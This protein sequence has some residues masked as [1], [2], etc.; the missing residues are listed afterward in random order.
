MEFL[1]SISNLL[2]K[3][4]ETYWQKASASLDASAKIYGFRVD[5]VHSETFKF[6]GGLSRNEKTNE[7]NNEAGDLDN[8]NNDKKEKDKR[9]NKHNGF[10][11]LEK[12]V[13]KINLTKYDLEFEIDPLFKSMTA[14]FNESGAR[15]LLLNNFP[16][17]DNLDV[18][19]ESKPS[20]NQGAYTSCSTNPNDLSE[21][22]KK[23]V[24]EFVSH[25]TID[26]LTSMQIAPDLGYFKQTRNLETTIEK[27]FYHNFMNELDNDVIDEMDENLEYPA[28][29]NLLADN[30]SVGSQNKS[31]LD[32]GIGQVNDEGM[33]EMNFPGNNISNIGGYNNG[34]ITGE[35]FSMFKHDDIMEYENKF[36]DGSRNI[37][38]N[39]PQFQNFIK[40]FTKLDKNLYLNRPGLFK[41]GEK[42]N[43]RIKKEEKLFE[44]DVEKEIG[45]NEIFGKE[46]KIKK[47]VDNSGFGSKKDNKK[48]VKQFY[49]YDRY[50]V[51]RLFTIPERNIFSNNNDINPNAPLNSE[52]PIPEDEGAMD[53]GLSND[54][55]EEAKINDGN[56][57][58]PNSTFVKFDQ[59]YEKKFG[60]LY[61]RFDVRLIKQNLW[62]TFESI[63][64]KKPEVVDFKTV[65]AGMSSKIEKN[66]LDNISTS[67]CF[68]CFLHLCNEKSKLIII[69]FVGLE[70]NQNNDQTF[71][72]TQNTTK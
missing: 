34:S 51:F 64:E 36:G 37:L 71:Y 12:D 62:K 20:Y 49:N 4:E 22:N 44:F 1:E 9:A 45:R 50:D 67:T 63:E 11:T 41:P 28:E 30:I 68:V 47:V 46:S 42:E 26:E 10:S 6:L 19:L 25:M 18:L 24:D 59:E 27:S 53:P 52:N 70:L 39:F 43:K 38:K 16:L 17:D 35:G 58:L 21:N 48:K 29:D 33:S 54:S 72:I 40:A 31:E 15:G 66:I 57:T 14:K 56:Q 61:K 8:E 13:K 60:N 3:N 2:N 23:I 69:I 55:T 65:V 7:I 32:S 5:S